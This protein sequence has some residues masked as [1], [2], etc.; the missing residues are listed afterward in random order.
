[1]QARRF[2]KQAIN[3]WKQRRAGSPFGASR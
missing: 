1:L 2:A 3:M